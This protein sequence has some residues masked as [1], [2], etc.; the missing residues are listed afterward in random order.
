MITEYIIYEYEALDGRVCDSKLHPRD[1]W[2]ILL[3]VDRG[4]MTVRAAAE[5]LGWTMDDVQEV[6]WGEVRL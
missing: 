4:E 6:L 1:V 5:L 3:R 2:T